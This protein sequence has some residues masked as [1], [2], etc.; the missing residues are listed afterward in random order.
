MEAKYISTT[1]TAKMIRAALK[2]AFAGI[3]FSVRGKT[4]SGGSSITVSWTDG[5]NSAQV[6]AVIG[7]FAG[8][9]FDGMQDLKSSVRTVINGQ[10]VHF[11][12]DYIH[13]RRDDSDAA[14]QRAIDRVARTYDLPEGVTLEAYRRGALW[15]LHAGGQ[16][17]HRLIGEALYKASDRMVAGHSPTA[18]AVGSGAVIAFPAAA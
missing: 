8:S 11:C 13:T 15:N 10:P 3:T 1:D 12:A 4:Y 5:P 9:T 16:D 7:R 18:A 6:E 14:V 2:E 17:V